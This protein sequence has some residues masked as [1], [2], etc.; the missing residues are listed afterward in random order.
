MS[1]SLLILAGMPR[2][3]ESAWK[4][5]YEYVIKHLDSDLAICYGDN[6]EMPDYLDEIAKYKWKFKEPSDW[7]NYY[8]ENY[9]KN[10]LAYLELGKNTGLENSGLIGFAI[11]DIIRKNYIDILSNYDQIIFSR[12]DLLHVDF[13][14]ILD[15][16]YIWIAEGEDYGG[17]N[18][19]HFIFPSKFSSDILNVCSYIDNKE[20]LQELPELVNT[21]SVWF[22][23]LKN[24]GLDKHINRYKRHYFTVSAPGDFTRWRVAEYSLYF[25]KGVKIKYPNEFLISIKRLLEKYSLFSILRSSFH[26]YYNYKV[27]NLRNKYAKF[28]PRKLKDYLK[29]KINN[30]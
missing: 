13:H 2:G 4:S 5:T 25:S 19:R 24:N 30:I 20:S 16:Q 23:H 28:F 9:S 22:K 7:K 12:Y 11:K 18:D 14:P 8:I 6:I 27:L 1:K 26:L 3:G 29:S 15:N 10:A 21:E 17:V